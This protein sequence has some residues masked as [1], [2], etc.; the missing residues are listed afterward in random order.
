MKEF[1]S[2][3]IWSDAREFTISNAGILFPV[4]AAAAVFN[5][6][7]AGPWWLAPVAF[8]VEIIAAMALILAVAGL[9]DGRAPSAREA[10]NAAFQYALPGLWLSLLKI[11][12]LVPLFLCLLVPGVI[13]HVFWSFALAAVALRGKKGIAALKYSYALVS[14]N[15]GP[16]F[17]LQLLFFMI[18]LPFGIVLLLLMNVFGLPNTSPLVVGVNMVFSALVMPWYYSAMVFAMRALE[19][20]KEQDSPKAV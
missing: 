8:V 12:F 5:G 11:L 18:F 4:Y 10:Y 20:I 14:D 19:E 15:W 1:N 3:K 13:F 6:L 9:L 16:V 7:A 17:Q 2:V